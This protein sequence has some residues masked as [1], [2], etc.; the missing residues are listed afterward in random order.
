MDAE[1]LH[2]IH[3]YDAWAT[4]RILGCCDQ[5]TTE[6]FAGHADVPWGSIRNQLVHQFVVHKRWLCWADGSLS[7]EDAYALQADPLDYPDIGSVREMWSQVSQQNEAFLGRLTP[8]TLQ[9][10]LR[11]EQPGYEFAL[12]VGDVMLHVAH[13]SM[14]HRTETAMAL[15]RL[16]A[17]PG[18]ID[19]LFYALE[20]GAE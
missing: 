15:T 2:A 18:D 4:E 11:V 16:D 1:A 17:S 7:G 13:H 10:M 14:Q 9:R 3:G 8:D 12:S 20:A 6:Q 5:L 19:Y